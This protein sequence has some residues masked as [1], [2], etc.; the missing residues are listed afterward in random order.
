MG[1]GGGCAAQEEL[2]REEVSQPKLL[3]QPKQTT[4]DQP[5]VLLGSA[6]STNQNLDDAKS[7]ELSIDNDDDEPI[8]DDEEDIDNDGYI[9]A[10]ACAQ[11]H[12]P[13]SRRNS[14]DQREIDDLKKKKHIHQ[15]AHYTCTTHKNNM[16]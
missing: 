11:H 16:R 12:G 2:V 7:V 15:S 6:A 13:Y 5:V 4:H 1:G 9:C 8:Y 14:I 10:R 3:Q